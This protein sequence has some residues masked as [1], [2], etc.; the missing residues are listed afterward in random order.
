MLWPH[1]IHF[2]CST[3]C[4]N[5][6][7]THAN[8]PTNHFFYRKWSRLSKICIHIRTECKFEW[9]EKFAKLKYPMP[10]I[11]HKFPLTFFFILFFQVPQSFGFHSF[12]RARSIFVFFSS[13]L[14]ISRSVSVC[15]VYYNKFIFFAINIKENGSINF[16]FFLDNLTYF[17]VSQTVA[18]RIESLNKYT[19][20]TFFVF[21]SNICH[22]PWDKRNHLISLCIFAH[23]IS[24]NNSNWGVAA[25][26]FFS[27][28]LQKQIVWIDTILL[29]GNTIFIIPWNSYLAWKLKPSC[30]GFCQWSTQFISIIVCTARAQDH[31]LD[32]HLHKLLTY[33]QQWP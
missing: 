6:H 31:L 11:I 23:F 28:F 17:Y 4:A 5:T 21:V 33:T 3:V 29:K 2:A 20:I 30:L 19:L 26:C 13:G 14:S 9:I 25:S 22:N 18:W 27:F 1:H 10:L 15:V 7:L 8:H 32:R 12:A 24:K 16:G